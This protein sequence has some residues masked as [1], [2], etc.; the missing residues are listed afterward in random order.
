MT[1][2]SSG[3][4]PVPQTL[5]IRVRSAEEAMGPRQMLAVPVL[6]DEAD[7]HHLDAPGLE[8]HQPLV[9]PRRSARRA[10]PIMCGAEGP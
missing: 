1:S 2:T 7:G 5:F 9:R 10:M 3:L 6:D 4:G 8:R